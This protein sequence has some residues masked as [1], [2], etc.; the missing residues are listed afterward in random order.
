M[1]RTFNPFKAD[2][3]LIKSES[4]AGY[5][6]PSRLSFQSN[7][8]KAKGPIRLFLVLLVLFTIGFYLSLRFGAVS[9]SHAEIWSVLRQPLV[10]N[11]LQDVIIDLR[12]P[13]MVAAILVGAAMATAGLMMQ[14]ITRNPIAD[15]GFLGINAGAGLALVIGYALFGSMHY[16][17]ILLLCLLGSVLSSA[18]VYG[19]SYVPGRGYNQLRLLL[20]GAMVSSLFSAI[21]QAITIYFKLSTAVIGWQAGGLIGVNWG[22]IR[23]IGPIIIV[24]LSLAQLFAHQLTILSFN[25]TIAKSLGQ[26]TNLMTV[27]LL[28]IT[29]LLSAA[30]VAMIGAIAFVGLII[31]HAVKHFVVKDYRILLPLTLFG[32]ATFM[33]WV[34]LVCRI[35]NPPYETPLNAIISLVGLPCFLW[36]VRKGDQL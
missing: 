15:P 35:Y 33:L 24:G 11:E 3:S 28:G 5:L 16:S 22:M 17:G 23:I 8:S 26:R 20:A 2:Q 12:L 25:E 9:Y 31:P 10:S 21:G 1:S 7:P 36:L 32:G 6:V 27:V 29:L 13:R 18:L 4:R 14:G 34:D 19:L 30:G